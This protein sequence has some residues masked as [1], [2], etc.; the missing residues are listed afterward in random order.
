[1]ALNFVSICYLCDGEFNGLLRRDSWIEYLEDGTELHQS[2]GLI[3]EKC[4]ESKAI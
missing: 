4:F 1:M 2:N 3:C